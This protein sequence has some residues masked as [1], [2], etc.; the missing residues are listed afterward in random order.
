MK[1]EEIAWAVE[2]QK[3]LA[4]PLIYS[5][6]WPDCK[7]YCLDDDQRDPVKMALDVSGADKMIK[8]PNGNVFFL[9]QRFR[10]HGSSLAK[11]YDDFTLRKD[12]PGTNYRAECYKVVEAVKT[13]SLVAAYYAYGHVN[14]KQDGFKKFR[15][16]H[17]PKFIEHWQSG[18]LLPYNNPY[19]T[20]NSSDFLA[21][22]FN[23]IP[24]DCVFWELKHPITTHDQPVLESTSLDAWFPVTG[25]SQAE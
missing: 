21:W 15:I 10:T 9:G 14:L 25:G 17:F 1:K 11:G 7:V 5:K 19:N 2:K 22:R 8:Q 12:R 3:E 20:D 24:Q 18:R 16:L 13:G 23:R 4:I 6:V